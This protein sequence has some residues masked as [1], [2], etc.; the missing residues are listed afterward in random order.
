LS[1]NLSHC[2]LC[3]AGAELQPAWAH[4]AKTHIDLA[5]HAGFAR[6]FS[7]GALT[8]GLILPLETHPD[9]VA[10]TM[11]HHLSM[12]QKAE[13]LGFASLWMRD[14]PF[15]DPLYG[16]VG[17]IFEPLTYISYLGASTTSIA[18]GTAG[19]VLPIR[20]PLLL[21]KQVTTI[22]QLSR[23]RM[24][25]GLSSGDR[26]SDYPLFGIDIDSRGERLRDAFSVYRTVSEQCFPLF[27]SERFGH[28]EGG[29]DLVPKPPVGRTPAIAVGRGQQS[30]A[31]I[32]ANMDGFISSIPPQSGLSELV[33][34]WKIQIPSSHHPV[35]KPLGIGGFVDL[36][37]DRSHPV[38]RIRGGI[39]AGSEALADYLEAAQD[40]G[41]SHVAMNPKVSRRPYTELMDELASQLLKRFPTRTS[42][43][44]PSDV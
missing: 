9:S 30:V 5:R 6:C 17:Q 10:P 3:N 13:A 20:E 4:A 11:Q 15:Y 42:S 44:R 25:L 34:D 23:S 16:D 31:W 22:D 14:I 24:L 39:R 8:I 29:L 26:P 19:I 41:I 35:F 21:A 12:A 7:P 38:T 43:E 36:V 1:D 32:A 40:A 18:L 37:E 33:A 2:R 28:S 27:N